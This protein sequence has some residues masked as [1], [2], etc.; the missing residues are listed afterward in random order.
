MLDVLTRNHESTSCLADPPSKPAVYT[1]EDLKV[2]NLLM[3]PV[4]VFDIERKAM[5]WANHAAL[6]LWNADSLESLLSRNFADDMSEATEIRLRE[7]LTKFKDGGKVVEQW[8]YYP[9]GKGPTT[10]ETHMSGILVECGR[11]VML[12]EGRHLS[13]EEID[14][15]SLRAV[16]ILRHLPVPVSQFDMEGN[17]LQQNP[18]GNDT[19]GPPTQL[20]PRKR[21]ST[22]PLK[23]SDDCSFRRRFL[24]Q[25]LAQKVYEEVTQG[26]DCSV[27]AELQTTHGP[28]WSSVE[29]RQARDPVTGNPSIL[30]STR[31]ITDLVCAKKEADEANA[32]KSE[33]IAV[34]AHE[35]R[36]PL[37]QVTGFID[38]L[39]Q[40]NLSTEQRGHVNVLQNAGSSLMAVINDL[41][42]YTKLEAGKM[43]LESI[44]FEPRAVVEGSVASISARAEQKGLTVTTS[45]A[46]GIPV[47]VVG[48]PNRLRQILLN[49]LNNAVKFT[50][51][52][53]IKV[54]VS[55]KDDSDEQVAI[56]FEVE[57][58][59]IGIS[60]SRHAQI[61][62]TYSQAD[63]SIARNYGGTGLGLTICERLA[64]IM[65]GKIGVESEL[66]RG[67]KFWFEIPFANA[68]GFQSEEK[69]EETVDG[70]MGLEILVAEDN[71][72]NQKLVTA[73]LKRLGHHVTVVS[74]GELAVQKLAS[75]KFDLVLMD[76][77]MPV[78]DGIEATKEIRSRGWDCPVIGL[79]ASY[80]RSELSF[81]Q[82]VGMNDCISKPVLTQG[83]RAAISEHVQNKKESVCEGQ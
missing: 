38:L 71:K 30:F 14:Q 80:Q 58:T 18:E 50:S 22:G 63:P 82:Q 29:V 27:E 77:Q 20:P 19:F 57:D 51:T 81:Y 7:Y 79:T 65:K 15:T 59:G 44:S 34:M 24:D 53:S 49:L 75:G 40:T 35:I 28:R 13:S 72:V 78:L 62:R 32:R 12:N 56:R 45:V 54:S 55:C 48:D 10:V 5:W 8:T 67:S 3:Q 11:M 23:R 66:G 39:S 17:I 6:D 43:D 31:D 73:M 70:P 68:K 76:I 74:N 83:L 16:E 36:T 46:T 33:F 21:A 37:H 9:R 61:F 60:E 47:K 26:K 25:D 69:T 4:W 1:R 64:K 2:F 41:L 52:G 42:D